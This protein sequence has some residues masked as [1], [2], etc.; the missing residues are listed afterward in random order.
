MRTRAR[1]RADIN[2]AA[3]ATPI[4]NSPARVITAVVDPIDTGA[5]DDR[6]DERQQRGRHRDDEHEAHRPPGAPGDEHGEQ[7]DDEVE[8]LLDRQAPEVQHGARS[9]EQ[10]GV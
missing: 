1:R 8:L 2:T 3:A 10:V 6:N 9:A 5:G 4:I 7:S